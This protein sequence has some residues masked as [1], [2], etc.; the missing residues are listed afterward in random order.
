MKV[1]ILT[2]ESKFKALDLGR[3][4]NPKL[5]DKIYYLQN[6]ETKKAASQKYIEIP[7]NKKRKQ[8]YN[9]NRTKYNRSFIGQFGRSYFEDR[10]NGYPF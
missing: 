10:Y 3:L 6:T 9:H 4:E 2:E 8:E 1:Y 5:Y 7:E